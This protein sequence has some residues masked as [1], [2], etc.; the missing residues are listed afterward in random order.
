MNEL[1]APAQPTAYGSR[2]NIVNAVGGT[3]VAPIG[4]INQSKNQLMIMTHH[5]IMNYINF[6]L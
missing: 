4:I 6:G 3:I 1:S 5:F 2:R